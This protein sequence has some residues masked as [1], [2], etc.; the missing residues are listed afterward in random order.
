MKLRKSNEVHLN[1]MYFV[2]SAL[3]RL[4]LRH[5]SRLAVRPTQPSVP[6]LC[7]ECEMAWTCLRK[8]IPSSAEI[9]C[10]YNY[11]SIPPSVR[12][13][14][15]YLAIFTLT[16]NKSHYARGPVDTREHVSLPK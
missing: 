16:L 4:D 12:P 8:H 13:M 14:A 2:G 7:P 10:R 11:T 3:N 6:G 5:P 15:C 9:M 1:Y